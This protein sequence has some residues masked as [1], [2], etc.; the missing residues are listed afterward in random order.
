MKP[1]KLIECIPNFSEGRRPEVVDAIVSAIQSVSGVQILDRTSDPDHNRSVIT[2]AGMP[3]AVLEAAYAG[4][5][6]AAEL[7]DVSSHNGEHPFIGAADVVPF[8]PLAGVTLEEC[9]LLAQQLGKRVGEELGIPVYLYEAAATRPE[10]KALENIRQGGYKALQ[11]SITTDRV[12]DFGPMTLGKAGAVVI[13]VRQLLIAF[14]AYLTTDDVEIARKIASAVRH[15]SGGFH[16]LKAL[17][18]LVDGRAQVSM[19]FTDFTQTPLA[20]VIEAVRR[21][22]AHY[23]TA[24]H[25]TELIGLIPNKALV[26]AAEW[27][28]QLDVGNRILESRLD[29]AFSNSPESSFLEQLA[30]GTAAPG[31]GA[32]AAYAGAMAAAL[33]GM[34]ARLTIGKPKYRAVESRMREI[35]ALADELR[36][37]LNEAIA[38]D[39][40]SYTSVMLAYRLPKSTEVEQTQRTAAIEKALQ[41][42]IEVPLK[43][44]RTVVEVLDLLAEVA[45]TGNQNT[46][47]DATSGTALAQA[48]ITATALNIRVNAAALSDQTLAVK[49]LNELVAYQESASSAAS[50]VEKSVQSRLKLGGSQ[51]L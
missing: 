31:G 30:A 3:E 22:V 47:A 17:G 1:Q 41:G 23:G 37:K 40:D 48:A 20:R 35:A 16:Y 14:N 50:R 25:H 34:A 2:F 8:V 26:D 29:A 10:R 51:R 49:Y 43:M 38:A 27:Y 13:G 15:S 11:Q 12:P 21:E 9:V 46:I 6:K 19:N 32:A 36:T 42:A 39:A 5:S 4:I 45:E 18:L 24:I 33:A 44:I 28:L 7:I